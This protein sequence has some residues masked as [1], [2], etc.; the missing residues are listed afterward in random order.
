MV[1]VWLRLEERMS[2]DLET[3]HGWG[4]VGEVS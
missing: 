3:S 4:S 1:L 2:R